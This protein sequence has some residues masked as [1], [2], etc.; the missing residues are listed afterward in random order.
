MMI[1]KVCGMR[2]EKNVEQLIAD[3]AP[4]LMGLIF[5]PPSARFVEGSD[6]R[7]S[8]YKGLTQQK[9]GVFVNESIEEIVKK[10]L[11]YGLSHVQLHGDEPPEFIQILKKHSSALIIKVFRVGSAWDWELV[12]R[13]VGVAD[14]FLFDTQTADYGGSGKTFDWRILET[15][16]YEVPFLLSGGIDEGHI[17]AINSL[18]ARIPTCIGVDVN[19]RFEISPGLKDVARVKTFIEKVRLGYMNA[20]VN[21]EKSRI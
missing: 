12:E 10:I 13:Y 11:D 1:I 9:V 2:E 17:E 8:F 5:Y 18:A 16:P 7:A 14:W 3:T 19:S 20:G 6:I 21:R 4:D 15:Y